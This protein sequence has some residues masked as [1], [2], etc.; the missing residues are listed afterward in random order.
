LCWSRRPRVGAILSPR[1]RLSTNVSQN[2]NPRGAAIDIQAVTEVI[3]E[4]AL[5]LVLPRFSRLSVEEVEA[6]ATAGDPA[7]V[8]TVVDREVEA[9]LS[10][11]LTA[12]RPSAAVIGEEAAHH[13]P[14]LL[15]LLSSDEPLWLIDPID[16][17]KNFA[18]GH[19]GFGVMVAYVMEGRAQAAWVVLPARHQMFVAEV[20]SGAFVNGERI[21]V[22]SAPQEMRARG[23]V[24]VRYMPEGLGETVTDALQGRVQMQRPSGCAAVEYTDVLRG[25]VDFVIYYRLLPW[26]HAA[27]ALVLTEAGGLVSHISGQSYTARSA[28]QLTLVARGVGTASR[29]RAWLRPHVPAG[30]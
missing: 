13:R 10:K 14:D 11:A 17:T 23:A 20:G 1:A 15:R 29:L 21:R 27:P 19:S 8:V 18:A 28:N 5:T 4:A 16:G 25:V 3:E 6:K 7:D 9:H 2:K 12:L 22:P 30:S 26:D 24:L